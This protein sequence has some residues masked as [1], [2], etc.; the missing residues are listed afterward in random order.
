M[1]AIIR[2]AYE[3]AIGSANGF[4]EFTKSVGAGAPTFTLDSTVKTPGGPSRGSLKITG[5]ATARGNAFND[6]A[7]VLGRA[8]FCRQ[9][10]AIDVLPSANIKILTCQ[11]SAGTAVSSIRLTTAGKLQVWNEVAGTQVGSDSAIT[12]AGSGVSGTPGSWY[13]IDLKT[14]LGTGA[15]DVI[16]GRS[17]GTIMGTATTLALSDNVID[18]FPCGFITTNP[19][20]AMTIWFDD[21]GVNDDQGAN[22]NTYCKDDYCVL[23]KPTADSAR[24]GWTAGAAGT[25]NLWDAVNNTPPVGVVVGSATNTSQIK[26]ATSNI[27]DA[28]TATMESYTAAGVPAGATIDV[29]MAACSIGGST[30]VAQSFGLTI[31]T[32]PAGAETTGNGAAAITGTW[33]TGWAGFWTAPIYSPAVTLGTAPT[34]KIRQNTASTVT[35]QVAGMFMVADVALPAAAAQDVIPIEGGGYYGY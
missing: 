13:R 15:I 22:E 16:E 5:S 7:T 24:V 9:R 8:Y 20:V 29:V 23:L 32:N 25:T 27:T 28:Y 30:T 1:A 33:D 12:V 31:L 35:R 17:E 14:L 18:Y 11:D 6:F 10:F 34:L 21:C 26:D 3:A 2:L 4:Y 19:G